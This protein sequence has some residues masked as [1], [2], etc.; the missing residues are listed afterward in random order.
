VDF[1]PRAEEKGLGWIHLVRHAVTT[2]VLALAVAAYLLWTFGRIPPGTAL[3]PALYTTVALGA[4]T[5]L[6]AAAGELLI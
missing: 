2:Y 3:G 1:R 5:S 6:G 4:V